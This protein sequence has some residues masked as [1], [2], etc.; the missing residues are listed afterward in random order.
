MRRPSAHRFCTVAKYTRR[1]FE[2][3]PAPRTSKTADAAPSDSASAGAPGLPVSI[4]ARVRIS[5]R[6]ASSQLSAGW[7]RPRGAFGGSSAPRI[8]SWNVAG[9]LASNTSPSPRFKP[10]GPS[11][12]RPSSSSGDFGADGSSRN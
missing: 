8:Q 4:A 2:A 12:D 5:T 7:P 11:M 6:I 3:R 1:S 10:N 9:C